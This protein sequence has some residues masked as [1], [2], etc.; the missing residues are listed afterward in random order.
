MIGFLIALAAL[1]IAA[2]DFSPAQ[3]KRFSVS[4]K[5]SLTTGSQLFPNPNSPDEFQRAQFSSIKDI[6]GFGFEFRYR[7]PETDLALALSADYL[8]KV[9]LTDIQVGGRV[10]PNEDGYRVIPVELTGYFMIPISGERVGV[11]MGGGVGAYV[12]RRIWRRANV[13]AATLDAGNGFGIHIL[14]GVSYRFN[15]VFS[16]SAELKFRDLQFDSVNQFPNEQVLFGTTLV[17]L[18]RGPQ[19]SRV[20][21]DGMIIQLCAVIDF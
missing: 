17:S 20:H 1:T 4:V 18:P 10:I 12:G 7:F 2:S 8:R 3:H 5:G 16:L 9:E 11:Y 6:F 13:E 14:S 15:D 19:T 21:T